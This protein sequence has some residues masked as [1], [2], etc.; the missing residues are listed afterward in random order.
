[1]ELNSDKYN[2]NS[3]LKFRINQWIFRTFGVESS[4]KLQKSLNINWYEAD[5]ILK[6]NI[7][8]NSFI[9]MLIFW[10]EPFFNYIFQSILNKEEGSNFINLIS[11][12]ETDV[13]G[14]MQ[15]ID[16]INQIKLN[17]EIENFSYDDD[18]SNLLLSFSKIFYRYFPNPTY[19]A[20]SKP[21]NDINIFSGRVLNY[22]E[23]SLD[24]ISE[25]HSKMLKIYQ[26]CNGYLTEDFTNQV[27]LSGI[28]QGVS[29]YDLD[30]KVR[31]IGEG[32][33]FWTDEQRKNMKGRSILELP[34]PKDYLNLT[35]ESL[36]L[37]V[38][39]KKPK[40]HLIGFSV[41]DT[42]AFYDRIIF[43]FPH[44]GLVVASPHPRRVRKKWKI[45][46][47]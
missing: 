16:K 46:S 37:A 30:L 38:K 2:M 5:Q 14:V 20:L 39:Q 25:P 13:D 21:D 44:S 27:I 34:A 10:G 28:A 35:F 15:C 40:L 23:I 22:E 42:E 47:S 18:I 6:G 4:L 24:S 3:E 33:L 19:Q 12:L 29:I 32:T 1:M 45:I 43:T 17:N 36:S 7:D 11:S 26:N 41:S 9:V 8:F 31:S